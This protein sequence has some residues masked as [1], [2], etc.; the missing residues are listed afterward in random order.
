MPDD[1]QQTDPAEGDLLDDDLLDHARLPVRM[2]DSLLELL[3]SN[4]ERFEEAAKQAALDVALLRLGR[5]QARVI[6]LSFAAE[7]LRDLVEVLQE[8]GIR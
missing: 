5:S 8:S 7:V 3:R 6:G 1:P 4:Q 2:A